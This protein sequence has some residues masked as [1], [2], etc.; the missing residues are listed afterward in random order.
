MVRTKPA[1]DSADQLVSLRVQPADWAA[2]RTLS[3][4]LF[5]TP[6][7][8]VRH[9]RPGVPAA[10]STVAALS[11]SVRHNRAA[12]ARVRTNPVVLHA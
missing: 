8:A 6:R 4:W 7:G 2:M 10:A 3:L 1:D 9:L 11:S 12:S 5:H